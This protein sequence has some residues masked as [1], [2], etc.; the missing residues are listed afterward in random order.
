MSQ[1]WNQ[2]KD[3]VQAREAQ[4]IS[5]IDIIGGA[6][7]PTAVFVSTKPDSWLGTLLGRL[8]WGT[9]IISAGLLLGWCHKD[10]KRLLLPMILST[11]GCAVGAE[12]AAVQAAAVW[13]AAR[14]MPE[15]PM[16]GAMLRTAPGCGSARPR[17]YGLWRC[18]SAAAHPELHPCAAPY[19]KS[20]SI[21]A[22]RLWK[23]SGYFL[24]KKLVTTNRCNDFTEG[25][26]SP[27]R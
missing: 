19:N 2:L 20:R 4:A 13:Q 11:V 14:H 10:K 22:K 26:S 5:T 17:W 8:P 16:P 23:H 15:I 27:L 6:D 18:C 7:G 1:F 12:Q 25:G 3:R 21:P 24:E 9:G